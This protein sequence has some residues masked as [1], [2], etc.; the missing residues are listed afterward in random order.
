MARRGAQ[1][2]GAPPLEIDFDGALWV[3][4]DPA[5][6]AAGTE[7]FPGRFTILTER[8]GQLVASGATT[9]FTRATSGYSC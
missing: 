4:D 1:E 3:P 8:S 2:C 9:V 5:A 7:L 6:F